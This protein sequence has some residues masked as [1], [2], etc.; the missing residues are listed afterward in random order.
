MTPD[1]DS[2]LSA[3]DYGVAQRASYRFWPLFGCSTTVAVR[4][5]G[6]KNL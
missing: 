2:I 4:L 3:G 6:L 1:T 5:Q